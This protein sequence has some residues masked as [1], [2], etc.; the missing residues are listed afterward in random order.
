[1]E[2]VDCPE[3]KMRLSRAGCSRLWTSARKKMPE[4]WEGRKAC[5]GCPLGA[6]RAGHNPKDQLSAKTRSADG[7]LARNFLVGTCSR[8]QKQADRMPG[9]RLCITCYNRQREAIR[10]KSAKGYRPHIAD[11][12]KK[13]RLFVSATD[14]GSEWLQDFVL[15][16]TEL[17]IAA[18]G[19]ATTPIFFGRPRIKSRVQHQYALAL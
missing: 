7:H 8:C 9:G 5:V 14:G 15:S 1:M 18:A 3:L 12:L 13:D 17:M 4:N 10:G 11:L 16:R 19:Q 2:L 6:E